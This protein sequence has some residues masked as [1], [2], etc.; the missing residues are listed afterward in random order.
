MVRYDARVGASERVIGS[1]VMLMA[2]TMTKNGAD[3]WHI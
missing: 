2:M 1:H 3:M